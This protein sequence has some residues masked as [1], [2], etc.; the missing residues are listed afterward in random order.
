MQV[1]VRDAFV[2]EE[3][4]VLVAADY[5]QIELR[6]MAHFSRLSNVNRGSH[7]LFI[8]IETFLLDMVVLSVS[9]K[10]LI[11]LKLDSYS[12]HEKL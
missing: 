1:N 12:D 10:M 8:L 9:R 2:A 5:S 6:V 3:G 4:Y 7:R 11:S